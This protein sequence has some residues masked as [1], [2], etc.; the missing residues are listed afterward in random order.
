[1]E[2]HG[3]VTHDR[4]LTNREVL[5]TLA[6]EHPLR[7]HMQPV[8][9]TFDAVWYGVQEPD[10]LTYRSYTQAIDALESLARAQEKG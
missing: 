9:E 4:S 3:L 5:A 6:P 10:D 7:P 1:M 8:V 2:E